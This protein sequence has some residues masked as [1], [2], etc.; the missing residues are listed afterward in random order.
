MSS[1]FFRKEK[2][3]NK[4][5]VIKGPIIGKSHEFIYISQVE[6]MTMKQCSKFYSSHN[7]ASMQSCL[8]RE[9][10]KW[11]YRVVVRRKYTNCYFSFLRRDR[12]ALGSHLIQLLPDGEYTPIRETTTQQRVAPEGLLCPFHSC[13]KFASPQKKCFNKFVIFV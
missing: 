2:K 9:L 1:S 5:L 4:K 11:I 6:T 3:L 8:H 13:F 7:V 10:N 12:G